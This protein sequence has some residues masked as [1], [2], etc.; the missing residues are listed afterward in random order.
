MIRYINVCIQAYG[1]I[2]SIFLDK[3]RNIINI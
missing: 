3:D 1:G 2:S